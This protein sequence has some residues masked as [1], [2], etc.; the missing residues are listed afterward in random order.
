MV[1]KNPK[2]AA[3][4]NHG[5]DETR[6]R[7]LTNDVINQAKKHGATAVEVDADI[8]SGFSINVRKNKV[9]T[10]EHSNGK[11]LGVTV[12]FGYRTGS[13]TASDLTPQSVHTMVEKACHIA[14]FTN[15]D[16]FVGLADPELMAYDYHDLDIYHPWQIN[17]EEAIALTKNAENEGFAYDKR[18]TN[19]EGASLST[20]KAFDIYANS[21]GF[22]GTTASTKHSFACS[23]IAEHKNDMQRDYY[24]TVAHDAC[25]LENAN[26]VARKAA[27]RTVN[28]LNAQRITTRKCPIIFAAEI[29]GSLI[30]NFIGAI[31]GGNIYRKSSFLLNHL[32][33]PVFAKHI[34]I[35]ENPHLPK[36]L[37]SA[38]FD[39]EGVKLSRNNIVVDG[40][41]QR[42]V[43]DS[44]SARKLKMKTTG[45][46]G[47]VHN[48]I[49]K[50]SDLD[51]NGLLRKMGTGLLV[52]ELMGD[53]V[54]IV[55]GDYSRGVFGYWIENGRVQYPVIGATIASN[56]KDML[57]NVVDVGN[58]V[59]HRSNILTG[60]ILL[61]KMTVAGS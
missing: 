51:L 5:F 11:T 54:N 31:H 2:K 8:S 24:Y 10:I 12:Y 30:G 23:F 59:D 34:N 3:K 27:K 41:L 46:A 20:F 40:V 45:N 9:E 47:G 15:E 28:R 57:L 38:A 55:T 32:H 26:H 6:F 4:N 48:V 36:A 42:Y 43:L 22:C 16:P 50:T 33:K 56:L 61:D 25:D 14:R 49:L 1:V 21:H 39:G 13:A 17:I 35:E 58:D 7:D 37:G 19:S 29:A 53:G 18:L 52:T 44:Y 60:S